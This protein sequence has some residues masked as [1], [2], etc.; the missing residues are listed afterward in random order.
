MTFSLIFLILWLDLNNL[1]IN[2]GEAI[3]DHKMEEYKNKLQDFGGVPSQ[4][5]PLTS[6]KTMH[7]L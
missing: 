3:V 2:P 6:I 4:I 5:W 1:S 7:F